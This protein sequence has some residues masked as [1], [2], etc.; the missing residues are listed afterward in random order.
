MLC[1]SQ[2]IDN[3]NYILEQLL[4]LNYKSILLTNIELLEDCLNVA[5]VER[6]F[7]VMYRIV[8]CLCP[9]V[10]VQAPHDPNMTNNGAD[11]KVELLELIRDC[12]NKFV[13]NVQEVTTINLA[14]TVIDI[15]LL[16]LTQHLAQ[17]LYQNHSSVDENDI[18]E[19][20][21]I[22]H[23]VS[24]LTVEQYQRGSP[25]LMTDTTSDCTIE[26]SPHD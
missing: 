16:L 6:R 22:F 21:S 11:F 7:D 26:V 5:I 13:K 25:V 23:G 20:L 9:I 1:K 2:H 17:F 3:L 12:L 10:L 19:W 8:Q 14:D 24:K 4:I 18:S 15:N